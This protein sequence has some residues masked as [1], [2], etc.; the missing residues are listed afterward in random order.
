MN[1]I[2]KVISAQMNVNIKSVN[3]E[4]NDG[5]FEGEITLKIHNVSFLNALIKKLKKIEGVK[6]IE[7]SYKLD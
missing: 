4:S 3:I 7:R 6:T 5:L 2:T 1:N